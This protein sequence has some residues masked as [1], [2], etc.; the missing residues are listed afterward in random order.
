[1]ARKV[2]DIGAIGNDG[3]GDSI[4][5]SFRKVNDNFR[6]LYSSLGLGERLLFRGLGDTPES[7]IGQ[8]GSLLAVNNTETGIQYK[9]IVSGTG[10]QID[11]TTNPNEILVST[12]FSEISGDPSPQLGGDLS[13]KSG[14]VQY[15]ILDLG[16]TESPIAP[17]F[18]HEAVNKAY[19]DSKISRAG[20]DAIDPRTGVVNPSFGIMT[21]PLV[22]SRDPVPSD[23]EVYNGLVAATK[24]Y[25]DSSAFGSAANLYVATSGQDERVGVSPEL[26]GRALAYAYRTLE[27]ALKRAEELVLE[28]PIEI[29]PYKKVLTYGGNTVFG[30]V[31]ITVGSPT[32]FTAAGHGLQIGASIQFSTTDALPGGLFSGIDY[33]IIAADTNTFQVSEE[34]T[35]SSIITIDPQAGTQTFRGINSNRSNCT[36]S[37]I[38][39]APDSG[40]GVTAQALMSVDTATLAVRGTNYQVGDIITLA[41]GTSVAACTIEVLSTIGNPG[42]VSTFRIISQGSYSVLPGSLSVA[43]TTDS[44]FGSGARFDLTYKVNKINVIS[45]GSDYGLVSVR[46]VP[47]VSDTTGSGAFGTAEVVDGEIASIRIT[48]QGSGFT[49]IPT[50]L[51]NLPRFKIFT[52]GL[53]TDF[54]GDIL[55]DDPR[56]VRTRDIR[57]GLFLRG[58]TSGAIAQI[59]AHQ[60]ELDGVDEIFDVD[61]ISGTFQLGEVI[62]YGDVT[63]TIQISILVESGIYEENYPL[64]IPQN[65][66]IIGDEFRRTIVRPKPGESSSPWSF[67]NFRRDTEIDGLSTSDQLF[68]YHYL[69]DTTIPVYPTIDN[70]GDYRS[71]ADL[72][73]INK[74]FLQNE[75]NAWIDYQISQGTTPFEVG[76]E[77]D[78]STYARDIGIVIDSLIFDLKYG[79]QARSISAA[80]K[81]RSTIA[82]TDQLSETVAAIEHLDELMQLIIQNEEIDPVYNIL[83]TQIIDEAFTAEVGSGTVI[84]DLITAIVDIISNSGSV[85]YPNDNDSIDVFLCNDA[86]IIRALTM[87]G[88]GGFSL[89]LDPTGQILAK[90]PYC[91]ESAA[92]S[93]SNGRQTFAGGMFVDGFTGNLQFKISE[94][95]TVDGVPSNTRLGVS[96][97][98]RFPQLP[99]SFIVNDNV[100]RI[101]YVRDFVFS[102]DNSTATLVLD[103]VT[104]YPFPIGAQTFTAAIGNP[105]VFTKSNH[106]L[107]IGAT[108][109]F[110]TTGTL[111]APLETGTEYYV[112]PSG[113]TANSFSVNSD[114]E[115]VSG[116]E[117]TTIGVGV[118]SYERIYEI[119]MPGNRSMLSN[120]FTQIA[121][122]G[123]GLIAT[124][125]GL[126]EAVSMFTYYCYISYYSLN[127][128]QIR[129]IGGSSAHGVY[130]LVS[131][132]SD[133]LEIPTPVTLYHEL[134]TGAR[135]VNSGGL[136][137]AAEGLIVY[138]DNYDFVPLNNSEFEVIHA[139][140]GEVYRYAVNSVDITGL[141]I[142]TAKLSLSSTGN[143]TTSGLVYEIPDNTPC[144][145]RSLSQVVLTGDVV[146][147]ATRPSTALLLNESNFVYRIL[148]FAEYEDPDGDTNCSV[149]TASPA[150]V[151]A[152]DHNQLENYI[153][154]FSVRTAEF[155]AAISGTTLTVSAV[156]SG[157]IVVGM[158][159]S[160][161]G[162]TVGTEI[163]GFGSGSGG[164]GTYI[165]NISQ[166]I[167]STEMSGLGRLPTG[168]S[169]ATNY[170]ILSSG[171]TSS[172]FQISTT[173]NGN[174]VATTA[175]GIGQVFF[176]PVG[177]ARTTLRENYD[178]VELTIYEPGLAVGSPQNAAITVATETV[179]TTGI[180]H[181]LSEGDVVRLFTTGELPNGLLT[182]RHYHVLSDGLTSTDFKVSLIPGGDP[183]ETTGGQSGTHSFDKVKGRVGDT[184]FAV[185]PVGPDDE[186]RLVGYKFFWIGVEYEITD[187]ESPVS[188]GEIY[189]VISITPALQSDATTGDGSV[190]TFPSLPTLKAGVPVRTAGAAG[191]LTIRISL[192]R[193]TSHDLLEIGTGS[194]ADT[195]YPNEIYGPAVNPLNDANETQER[196]SGRTFYVTTDQ[197]GNF[198]VGPYFRVDQGTGTVTFS[199]A[200]ALSNLDGLGFKRGVPISEFSV[201]PSFGDNA[202]D[203]VPTENATRGYIDKRL[204]LTHS[205]SVV[206]DSDIIPSI[207]G[208]FMS[209]DGQLAMKATMNLGNNRIASLLD[210]TL[211]QDAVNLRS[212]TFDKFQD[213][214]ITDPKSAEIIVFTGAADSAI[215]ATVVGDISFELRPGV[216]SAL[217]TVNAQINSD[218]IIDSDVKSD[219]AIAQSKLAMNEATTR[220]NATGIAQADLGLASFDSSQFTATDGWI[221]VA[222]NG[223][224]ITKIQQIAS[225]TVLGNSTL[226][227]G[228][229]SQVSFSTVVDAGGGIK[230][231]QYS[232]GTGFLYRNNP[233]LGSETVDGSYE[234][235]DMDSALVGDALVVRDGDGD[236]AARI[237]TLE[238]I[239]LKL[240][241]DLNPVSTLIRNS[242]G[243]GGSTRLFGFNGQGGV[244][245][246][247]SSIPSENLT[248]YANELHEF[249]SQ[250]SND[251]APIVCSQIT[252]SAITT[253]GDTTGGT[254]TGQ[255][256]LAST[257]GGGSKGNSRLQATYAADLAEFYEGDREYETGTVLVFGGEKEVT[258]SSIEG[259]TRVAGV[260]SDNAAYSMYGACPGFKN[261]IALQGRVPCKV[262]GKIKKG[263]LLTTSGIPGVAGLARDAKAGT[264]IGKALQDYDSD[265]IGMIEVAVGRV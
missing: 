50:A 250:D 219:A 262:V 94:R 46:I 124:N 201:D 64:K 221:S 177:L 126:T 198:R 136:T 137:N 48:D 69:S 13:T 173:L 199:A 37:S 223:L 230:K 44:E 134:G 211:S 237:A 7:Y 138:V 10:V 141:P 252:T 61:I 19:A 121:D 178:Y 190:L 228:N 187:Y 158:T 258:T 55:S 207:T 214:T 24:R 36:L 71:A 91:Q 131:E 6:E 157:T 108:L 162:I 171:L 208:G 23:D 45:S 116:I 249:R 81:Y 38:A 160:V 104:P 67:I 54:T 129:S 99:A 123:Y 32:I 79:G 213:T 1:M 89:V 113:F 245:V 226:L 247:T 180:A 164:T 76:F 42:A 254:I 73:S 49:A 192:T 127:G 186:G 241:T 153:V 261:Q 196:G 172:Q 77:Y 215:N 74:S 169:A 93:K 102:P 98:L 119:L 109:V 51:V 234:I 151:T 70:K 88:H 168:L 202:T 191:T 161:I 105:G 59:L 80:I 244:Y 30:E 122:M 111:P 87:Q 114:P 227:S 33:Y 235:V 220:I 233:S 85:N 133:P 27:A 194:Y 232:S 14:A 53:R 255:W 86:N 264:L 256:T 21:G 41:G 175:A 222:N 145:I 103:E 115:A 128:G 16:T 47:N 163:I 65:V 39:V 184:E 225:R 246:N 265:R 140:D 242:A 146:D 240:E 248:V 217:N 150:V 3:T 251:P 257:P 156:A 2:I 165:L 29:G 236:F 167:S 107:Q 84:T 147:V 110:S 185:V 57:E 100:Y 231:S 253:G 176:E 149:S 205:G 26:Q 28:A 5:E 144:V 259:D 101:N 209:L 238:S 43:T 17:I 96:G 132:G 66:A 118:H 182:S 106:Q 34:R 18:Q 112:V 56:A 260:V 75:V 40:S 204:G 143:T 243:G 60:G 8:E 179:F 197:F 72:I 52:D 193:V 4:R 155:T 83:R 9:R 117:I 216:D 22:L 35:G 154:Q 95:R 130:A 188:S 90:S 159:I 68:G 148:Q 183:V 218:T 78:S 181:G 142:G 203:T 31:V 82:I 120:D 12:L 170:Y 210:P 62:S 139:D 15:R 195:N 212:L 224:L 125:G 239:S 92:F 200:I 25:V 97:L 63:K 229:V 135:V 166:S 206:E 263:D 20:V 189:G 11:D 152:S 174:P 58:E